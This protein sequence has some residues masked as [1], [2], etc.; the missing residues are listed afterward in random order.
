MVTPLQTVVKVPQTIRDNSKLYFTLF[1]L[2]FGGLYLVNVFAPQ[3]AVSLGPAFFILLM[4][5]LVFVIARL[6]YL[7]R[8]PDSNIFAFENLLFFGSIIA[9]VILLLVFVPS[10]RPT[11]F[12]LVLESIKVSPMSLVGLG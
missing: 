1:I 4:G 9:G 12:S 3:F 2:L 11:S 7:R 5:V 8:L 6:F 10:I